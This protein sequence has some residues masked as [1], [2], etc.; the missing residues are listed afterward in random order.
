MIE[1][2]DY[3]ESDMMIVVGS[4]CAFSK[5]IRAYVLESS[6]FQTL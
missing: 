6:E 3:I 1:Q 5:F 2:A 4:M